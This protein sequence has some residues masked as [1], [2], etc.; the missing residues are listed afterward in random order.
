MSG[1]GMV[2]SH[3]K[4]PTSSQHGQSALDSPCV[5]GPSFEPGIA[6][7]IEDEVTTKRFSKLSMN[8]FCVISNV[9]SFQSRLLTIVPSEFFKVIRGNFIN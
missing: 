6:R 1:L 7:M 9:P 5:F 3:I 4:L 2:D 8:G